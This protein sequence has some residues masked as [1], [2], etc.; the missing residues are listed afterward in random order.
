MYPSV[1]LEVFDWLSLL[2]CLRPHDVDGGGVELGLDMGCVVFLDHLD[3]GAAV[4]CD[5]IDVRA[6]HEA[7]ANICMAQAVSGA[8]VP[9]GRNRAR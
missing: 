8:P 9:V 3:A 1:L 7:H 6:F 4:F 5:L 2:F